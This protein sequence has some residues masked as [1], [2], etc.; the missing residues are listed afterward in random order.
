MATLNHDH[1]GNAFIFVKGAPEQIVRMSVAQ[2]S[3]T[4]D[5]EPVDSD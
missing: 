2:R 4:G 5:A 1:D 3:T